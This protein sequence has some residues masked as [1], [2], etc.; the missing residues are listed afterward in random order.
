MQ[1][2]YQQVHVWFNRAGSRWTV[3]T[4]VS[5]PFVPSLGPNITF[6]VIDGSGTTG[7]VYGASHV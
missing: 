3:R 5:A 6:A 4:T 7:L 2:R 1:V